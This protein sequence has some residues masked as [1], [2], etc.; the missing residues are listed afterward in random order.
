M[1]KII[2]E[3]FAPIEHV[4]F[5]IKR[6][7]V[8][9][10]EQASGKSTILK[11]IYFFQY[12]IGRIYNLW[13][14]NEY[15]NNPRYLG[16]FIYNIIGKIKNNFLKNFGEYLNDKFTISYEDFIGRKTYVDNTNDEFI[17]DISPIKNYID[18]EFKKVLN[19]GN[20]YWHNIKQNINQN[21]S[22]F[23]PASRSS[24]NRLKE[25]AD[26]ILK[27]IFIIPF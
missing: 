3:N 2:I 24:I 25:Y 15:K 4:D 26:I 9:F 13:W 16:E 27:K 14:N 21:Q 12:E 19:E 11:L 6:F 7:N 20:D 5:E 8:I 1:A 17:F 18:I 22:V 10:G 23:I